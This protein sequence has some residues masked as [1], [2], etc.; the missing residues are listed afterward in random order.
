VGL[1][2]GAEQAL[3][4]VGWIPIDVA[5]VDGLEAT[6]GGLFAL[7][8]LVLI[9]IPLLLFG[10]EL[11]VLCLAVAAG[12]I[13]RAAFGRPWVVQATPV[14][15][16]HGAMAWEANGWRRSGELINEVVTELGAGQALRPAQGRS[17]RLGNG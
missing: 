3:D 12:I 16:P 10:I 11:I 8:V 1:G 4:S 5:S 6:F 2:E 9:V 17:S 13:A 7:A 15:D 14:A